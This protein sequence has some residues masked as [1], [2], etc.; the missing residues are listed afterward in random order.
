MWLLSYLGV[1]NYAHQKVRDLIFYE[2]F[3]EAPLY[4]LMNQ[5]AV[6]AGAL[7]LLIGIAVRCSTK[8]LTGVLLC[9]VGGTNEYMAKSLY[10]LKNTKEVYENLSQKVAEAKALE[11]TTG[12]T[13]GVLQ[14]AIK[15]AE[16]LLRNSE[17][18]AQVQIVGENFQ[19]SLRQEKELTEQIEACMDESERKKLENELKEVRARKIAALGGE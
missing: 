19:K 2:V 5:V 14:E 8:T 16:P 4:R 12:Q 7:F 15:D 10:E 13:T 18:S 3:P 11:L 6:L 1:G 17:A 9:V